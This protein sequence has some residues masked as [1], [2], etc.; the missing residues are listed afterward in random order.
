[1]TIILRSLEKDLHGKE[2]LEASKQ[3]LPLN[4]RH[5]NRYTKHGSALL[6]TTIGMS[7]G[8]AIAGMLGVAYL[9][10]KRNMH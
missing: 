3:A 8:L 9:I 6:G 7:G 1:M 10:F 5:K 2:K 4:Y